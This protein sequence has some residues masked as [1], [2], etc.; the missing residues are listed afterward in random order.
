MTLLTPLSHACVS[1]LYATATTITTTATLT[2]ISSTDN[3]MS[4]ISSEMPPDKTSNPLFSSDSYR[5]GGS[6][7]T[8]V[9]EAARAR[10][11]VAGGSSGYHAESGSGAYG[12]SGGAA[13][14][15]G[16]S[17]SFGSWRSGTTATGSESAPMQSSSFD[18]DED[19]GPIFRRGGASS[20][21]D[22]GSSAS[23]SVHS[24]TSSRRP[25]GLSPVAERSS[26]G[27]GESSEMTTSSSSTTGGA[28]TIYHARSGA[29]GPTSGMPVSRGGGHGRSGS[30]RAYSVASARAGQDDDDS[31]SLFRA[32]S[33]GS[34]TRPLQ[35]L[36]AQQSPLSSASAFDSRSSSFAMSSRNSSFASPR[37][38]VVG[39]ATSGMSWVSGAGLQKGIPSESL[40]V[41]FC[42]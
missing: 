4:D 21:F 35:P 1:P 23:M 32:T 12:T 9:A 27:Q 36:L 20:N 40:K 37:A 22:R 42:W 3:N 2:R 18:T 16:H 30:G 11:S 7:P 34:V 8:S 39:S 13:S 41:S 19:D 6:S 33:P 5:T 31:E 14:G 26:G 28:S 10:S 38:G 15:G 17:T 29:D 24:E 25:Y